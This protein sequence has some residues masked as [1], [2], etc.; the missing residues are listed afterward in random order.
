[1]TIKAGILSDTHLPDPGRGFKELVTQCFGDCDV[2]LHAGDLTSMKILDA[3]SDIE[4]HAVHGNMCDAASYRSLPREK[5]V[6]LLQYT[7]GLTHG[8]HLGH[9][10]EHNLWNLFPEVDCM[11]YGHTHRPVC[12]LQAGVLII[13]PGSFRGTGKYGAPGTYAVLEAGEY[14]KCT[15]HEVPGLV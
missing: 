4:V 3:F 9:D 5:T 15:L 8:A 13:N 1:M 7:I 12:H 10:I 11:I 6:K 2:I 14:L